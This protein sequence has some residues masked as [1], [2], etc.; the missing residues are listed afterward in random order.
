MATDL[1]NVH[2]AVDA[3]ESG[4]V[5]QSRMALLVVMVK[6]SKALARKEELLDEISCHL[7]QST[8]RLTQVGSHTPL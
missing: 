3:K 4:E 8:A 7:V 6:L 2:M 5:E 1:H